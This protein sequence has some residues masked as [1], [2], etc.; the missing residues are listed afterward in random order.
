[1]ACW[2]ST[3]VSSSH[4]TESVCGKAEAPAHSS[5]ISNRRFI[6][7]SPPAGRL[8]RDGIVAVPHGQLLELLGRILAAETVLCTSPVYIKRG[9]ESKCTSEARGPPN[10]HG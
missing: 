4:F 2:K 6:F 7:D 10:C 9:T 1:M 5:A 8:Y 3:A